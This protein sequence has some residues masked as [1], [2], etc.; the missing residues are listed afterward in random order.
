MRN[1]RATLRRAAA[2]DG[3]PILHAHAQI[4]G[5][6]NAPSLDRAQLWVGIFLYSRNRWGVKSIQCVR[7][8]KHVGA[9]SSLASRHTGTGRIGSRTER[10]KKVAP[11]SK[12]STTAL[13]A[14]V[15]ARLLRNTALP[16]T[17]KA[18]A[19]T[20]AMQPARCCATSASGGAPA[21]ALP[22]RRPASSAR[23]AAGP[24]L[25]PPLARRAGGSLVPLSV[26]ARRLDMAAAAAPAKQAGAGGAG[27]GGKKGKKKDD[28]ASGVG[29]FQGVHRA[30]RERLCR[31]LH[32]DEGWRRWSARR[33]GMRGPIG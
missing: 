8:G 33:A 28:G 15:L 3:L 6:A 32:S 18:A 29:V 24:S 26:S 19:A 11:G 5:T 1:P 17:T 25:L 16:T 9:S 23:V 14:T 31:C 21:S 13:P 22:L 4:Q 10:K 7:R 27:G 12:P 30:W 20:V 2:A